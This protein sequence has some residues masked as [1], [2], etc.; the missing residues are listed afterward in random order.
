MI[1]S[2]LG[3]LILWGFLAPCWAEPPPLTLAFCLDA[4]LQ[5]NRELLQAR[6]Q[7]ALV[8]GDHLQVRSRFLPHLEL[9]A[10]A[11]ARDS[12]RFD[13][14]P[15]QDHSSTQLH[16]AQRLFEFGP[17]ALEDV[18][19]RE[20]LRQALS[21]YQAR[22]YDLLSQVWEVYHLVLLHE[23]QLDRR[24]ASRAG[25]QTLLD[26]QQARYEHRLATEEE[27]LSAELDVLEED[28]AINKLERRRLDLLL[29][30]LRLIGQPLASAVVLEPVPRLFSLSVE[31]AIGTALANDVQIGLL[32]ELVAE[33]RRATGEVFWEFSP[34]L[35]FAAG[36]GAG[37]NQTRLSLDKMGR[38]WGLNLDSQQRLQEQLA[39]GEERRQNRWFAGF[40][41]RLPL[42]EGG[43]TLGRRAMEKARLRQLE[44]RLQD[45]RSARE[46]EVRQAHRALTEASQQEQLQEQRVALIRRR[47]AIH[48][49]LKEKGQAD[50]SLFEQVRAQFFAAQDSLLGAQENTLHQQAQLRRLMGYLE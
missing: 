16:L 44:L 42:F 33:Q 13:W 3:S 4:A 10:R 17:D 15:T 50:E 11:A 30:L 9:T 41:A 31:E 26:Q 37:Q 1:K 39:A 18:R 47:L 34:D 45:A 35:A 7:I 46:L 38:T 5:Q 24:R 14:H 32:R 25:F 27:K 21:A 40:E 29:E 23:E 48:Q 43:A 49:I 8:K 22:V 20:D 2:Y 12:A 6:E 28:L 36:F 19:L